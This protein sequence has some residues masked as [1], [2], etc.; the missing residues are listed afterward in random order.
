MQ[1]PQPGTYRH[2]K[3]NLYEVIDTVI[4]SETLEELI[5]NKPLYATDDK[6]NNKL[7]LRPLAMFMGKIRLFLI[8][9]F[10]VVSVKANASTYY[11]RTIIKTNLLNGFMIP[12]LHIEQEMTSYTSLQLNVHR[13]SLVLISPN[14]WL[15]ASLNVRF[16]LK[17]HLQKWYGAAGI[18]YNYNILAIRYDSITNQTYKGKMA[19]GPELRIGYQ[20]SNPYSL[21]RWVFDINVGATLPFVSLQPNSGS[22][23]IQARLFIGIGYQLTK[24]NTK[25]VS[26]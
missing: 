8:L 19:L 15:N 6:F 12:S 14:E 1:K 13:G 7:W 22:E 11:P 3:G 2:Y 18:A 25:P 4:H 16:Y 9:T 23:K 21:R 20:M 10:A 26:S 5:L 24:R 17:P